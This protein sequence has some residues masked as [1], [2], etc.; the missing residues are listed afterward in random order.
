ME[1]S[2]YLAAPRALE[3]FRAVY[4][5]DAEAQLSRYR[6]LLETHAAHFH[7]TDGA[8]L[9]SS[10]GRAEICGN[11]T[12]HNHGH[13]LAAA[14]SLDMAAVARRVDSGV[15]TLYSE[16][17]ARP[18]VV[19]LDDLSPRAHER[20]TSLALI[21][22]VAAR[23]KALGH[24]IGGFE[25]SVTSAV[26]KG[27]G[28]SSSAAFEVLIVT[29]F[30][31]LYGDG[32]I[33]PK[34]RARVAQYAENEY[35]MKPCGLMDQ[36]ASS[37]GGLTGIDFGPAEAGV[38]PVAYDF[39]SRGYAMCVV[40]AGGE[41]GNLTSEY[42]T[43]PAE[44]KA[45]ACALGGEVLRD[46][47][48]AVMEEKIPFLKG[49]VPDRAILRALH[50]YDEDARV[51]RL[52]AALQRDEL[53]TAFDLLNQSGESSWKL[54]QNLY[55][56]G[57]ENQEMTLALELTRRMLNGRGACRING[58]GYAGTILAFVPLDTLDAYAR[59]MNAVFGE[60]ATTVLAVRPVGPAIFGRD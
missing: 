32:A 26:F 8:L 60:R 25:A 27:S 42:A 34:L 28:L 10:P 36:M 37:V 1:L 47:D 31:A 45:V 56:P 24:P 15:V 41:H 54:L 11:H 14:V 4:G 16:G 22:G 20:E 13:V 46:I 3:A 58:G 21:R 33:D 17:Y 23:M 29:I 7:Q 38:T 52:T 44:M 49:K 39:R 35:F 30:D 43:M 53:Q 6:A 48:P 55:V 9:C 59:R 19:E 40:S 51:V 2:A 50:F 57:S 12:D 5:A 18:L